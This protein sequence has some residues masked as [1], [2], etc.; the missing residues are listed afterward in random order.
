MSDYDEARMEA[1][2]E[3]VAENCQE[4]CDEAVQEF[5]AKLLDRIN[6]LI[7]GAPNEDERRALHMVKIVIEKLDA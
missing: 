1:A 2:Q 4:Y 7:L 5:R 3:Y 6:D